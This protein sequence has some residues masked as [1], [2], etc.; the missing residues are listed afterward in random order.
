MNSGVLDASALLAAI[1]DEEGA[2]S[3]AR[4]ADPAIRAVNL[5]EVVPS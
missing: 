5:A 1:N 3:V 4:L 2:A